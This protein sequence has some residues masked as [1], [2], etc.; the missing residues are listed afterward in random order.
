MRKLL[1]AE[2]SRRLSSIIFI[3]EIIFLLIYNYLE[4]IGSVFGFE[5]DTTYFLFN[6]TAIICLCIAVN[7]SLQLIQELDNRTINNKL[8]CGF[9]K[10]IFYKTEII[11]GIIEGMILF[12]IDTISIIIL[13]IMQKYDTDIFSTDFFINLIIT[14]MIIST[15]T[16]ISTVLS[17]LINH[18]IISIFFVMAVTLFLLYGGNETVRSL[19]QP[20]QTTLFSVDGEIR[21]NPLYI[22]GTKRVAHNIHLFAS[23]YAQSCYVSY[24][25]HEK[26]ADK[27]N[28]SL[29]L[30]NIPYHLEFIISDTI[31]CLITYI[32]GFYLFNRR[33]LQ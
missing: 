26:Q 31:E 3:G 13:G 30:K 32:L 9:S 12:L 23:P 16:I 18:R 28:N 24:M 21:D 4:V 14:L 11:V 1:Q 6:K 33:N 29:I 15:V 19:N 10:S 27:S 20:A 25:L 8:F 5:V 22:E 7:V 2:L 17:I